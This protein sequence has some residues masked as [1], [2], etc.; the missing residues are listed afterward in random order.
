MIF[1]AIA[2]HNPQDFLN[3]SEPIELV[4]HQT[5]TESELVDV[6]KNLIKG[7]YCVILYEKEI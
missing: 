5:S 2:T 7:G 4:E 1:L 6:V 3:G